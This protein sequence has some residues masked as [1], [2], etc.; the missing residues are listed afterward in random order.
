MNRPGL[1]SADVLRL[2]ADLED[3]LS[4]RGVALDIQIVGGA[5]LLLHGVI[6][7]ATEDIDARYSSA[8]IVDQVVEEM[9]AEPGLPSKWLNS[10]AAAHLPEGMAWVAGPPG[11][12]KAVRIADLETLA[13][14]KLAAER[15]KDIEDLG[16]IALVLGIED[17]AALVRLAYLKYGQDS[18]S[19]NA[20]PANYLLVADEAIRSGKFSAG[21]GGTAGA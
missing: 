6:Y 9:A 13:A 7:R 15:Q 10:N 4:K 5:A 8:A 2:L 16:L 17:P 1:E 11:S 12:S 19:L 20:S 21:K 14:M 18:L 3:R